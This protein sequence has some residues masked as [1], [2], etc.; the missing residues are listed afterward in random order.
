MLSRQSLPRL[1]PVLLCQVFTIVTLIAV[2]GNPSRMLMAFVTI[3]LILLP[4]LLQRLF[5]CRI[6]LPLYLFSLFYALGPMLGHCYNFYVHIP[7]WDKLLHILGGI[8]FVILGIFLFS[9]MGGDH[10]NPL[11]CGVFALFFSVSVAVVWEFFEFG[12]DQLFLYDMQSDAIIT[13]ITSYA[14]GSATGDPATIG[15]IAAVSV[16]GQ[17]LPFQGYLDI[18]LLDTMADMLLETGGAFLTTALFLLDRGRHRL[19]RPA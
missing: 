1:L 9:L 4:E 19:I 12:M 14:L 15:D 17:P 11:L 8:I 3:L 5:R 16:N 2:W 18:G 7:H 10:E 13:S 6:C